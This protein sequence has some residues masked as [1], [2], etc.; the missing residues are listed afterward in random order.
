M[1]IQLG[2]FYLFSI[3]FLLPFDLALKRGGK[4][5]KNEPPKVTK[6]VPKHSNAGFRVLNEK[7]LHS[8]TVCVA[9]QH[10]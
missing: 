3:L 8:N 2:N 7:N 9:W 4:V 10:F 5:R 6:M 1:A